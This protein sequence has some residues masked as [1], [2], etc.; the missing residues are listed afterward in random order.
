M[1]LFLVSKLGGV[2]PFTP[3]DMELGEMAG[4]DLAVATAIEEEEEEE[5]AFIPAAVEYDPDAKPPMFKNRRCRLYGFVGICFI[6]AM[7]AVAVV[8][9]QVS[10]GDEGFSGPT[11]APTTLRESLGI[12][13]QLLRYLAVD[14]WRIPIRSRIRHSTG[15]STMIPFKL[16]HM[17]RT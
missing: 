5:D 4:G 8:V 14:I 16:I 13:Q 11:N 15:A 7:V 17:L 2:P 3:G 12:E 10:S 6:V 9:T 1:L